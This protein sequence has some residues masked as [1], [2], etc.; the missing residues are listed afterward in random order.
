MT[1]LQILR[2][3]KAAL[4]NEIAKTLKSAEE[5]KRSLE[6]Q[7]E[8]ERAEEIAQGRAEIQRLMKKYSLTPADVFGPGAP[9]S[10]KSGVP[11]KSSSY[12]SE[13]RK[14]YSGQFP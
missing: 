5:R 9:V 1:T 3:Q 12:L 6:A 10:K 13:I 11:D 2:D 4:E 14:Y 7:I 8:K